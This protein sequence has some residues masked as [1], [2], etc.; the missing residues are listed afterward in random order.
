MASPPCGLDRKLIRLLGTKQSRLMSASGLQQPIRRGFAISGYPESG[1]GNH[2]DL[3]RTPRPG[4]IE[5]CAHSHDAAA[6][7]DQA[8]DR[9]SP[10]QHGTRRRG[11]PSARRPH[12]AAELP[13]ALPH[14]SAGL[15]PHRVDLDD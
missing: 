8:H 9:P 4:D 5:R 3:S 14:I 15:W 2:R 6:A 12:S 10:G 11:A 1:Q 13:F 7:L